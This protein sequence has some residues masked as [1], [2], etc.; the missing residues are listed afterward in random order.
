MQIVRLAPA[1]Y[2]DI[3]RALE[4][5]CH[6]VPRLLR[7]LPEETSWRASRGGPSA[8]WCAWARRPRRSSR[9][10]VRAPRP[11]RALR[12]PSA[13]TEDLPCGQAAGRPWRSRRTWSRWWTSCGSGWRTEVRSAQAGRRDGEPLSSRL[14]SQAARRGTSRITAGCASTSPRKP[15]RHPSPPAQLHAPR[16]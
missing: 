1:G 4:L 11:P 10:P 8:A 6:Y 9:G 7:V 14:L 16:S 2:D 5:V 12:P 13:L 15:V 3:R